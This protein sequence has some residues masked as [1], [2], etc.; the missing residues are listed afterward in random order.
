MGGREGGREGRGWEGVREAKE[1]ER[2]KK[3]EGGERMGGR[4]ERLIIYHT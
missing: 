2:D 1:E 4:G 3:R